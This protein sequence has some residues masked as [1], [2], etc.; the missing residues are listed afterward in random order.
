MIVAQLT[1]RLVVAAATASL[2]VCALLSCADD[3]ASGRARFASELLGRGR[4]AGGTIWSLR[5]IRPYP[6]AAW[7]LRYRERTPRTGEDGAQDGCRSSGSGGAGS[8]VFQIDCV[9]ERLT[10]FGGGAGVAATQLRDGRRRYAGFSFRARRAGTR[11]TFFVVQVPHY[12]RATFVALD[13][14]GRRVGTAV[15]MP[16]VAEACR[17]DTGISAFFPFSF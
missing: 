9:S 5:T 16:R 14:H 1:R 10:V 8:A 4:L 13:A 2:V 15:T 12:S 11:E 17:S 7:C 3:P 6:D